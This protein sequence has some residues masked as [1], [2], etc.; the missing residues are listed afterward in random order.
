VCEEGGSP[1]YR[2]VLMQPP[3]AS[4]QVEGGSLRPERQVAFPE[5]MAEYKGLNRVRY[6]I[7]VESSLLSSPCGEDGRG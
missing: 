7:S 6:L 5:G 3:A 1:T 2:A 4:L